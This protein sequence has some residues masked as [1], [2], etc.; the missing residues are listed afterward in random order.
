MLEKYKE[1]FWAFIDLEK[2]YDRID[3]EALGQVLGLYGVGV[4]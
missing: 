4:Y 1:V 2:V 3:R